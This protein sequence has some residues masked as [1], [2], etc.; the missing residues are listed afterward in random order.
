[1]V[2]TARAVV[3]G[4]GLSGLTCAYRLLRAGVDTAVVEA[5]D[6]V[7]GRAWRIRLGDGIGFDAGCEVADEAHGALLDL[8]AELAV[9]TTLADP[10]ADE[11]VPPLDGEDLELFL[12]FQ[13]EIEAVV[14][15]I[16]PLHPDEVEGA[17]DLDAQTLGGRLLEL[18]ASPRLL[19][20]AETWYAV[21]TS[22]VPIGAMSLLGYAA[23][24]AAGAAPNG[25]R[26]RF[27]GGPSE[28]AER[29]AAALEDRIG[30]GAEAVAVEDDGTGVLV[31]L[32]DGRTRRASRAVVATPL[33][34]QRSIRFDP[35]LPAHRVEGLAKA[36][37]G[38]VVK[39]GLLCPK[40]PHTAFPIVDPRGVVY[41]PDRDLPLLVFF[42]GS[43]AGRR[44]AGLA[45]AARRVSIAELVGAEPQAF[46]SVAWSLERFT[47]GSYLIFGPGDLT[48]WGRLLA[49]PH[50]RIHFA[51]SEAS[52]L[53]SYMN[54]A[55]LAGERAAREML[56]AL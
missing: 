3:V 21:A 15:R 11:L 50:G 25:L 40:L 34:V 23:K 54:G 16:D 2:R 43:E 48:S 13:E 27:A 30:F 42:A 29:L 56:E 19:E 28:L 9:T 8:A 10:W 51:G 22:T 4:A 6:R 32:A 14:E 55:V 26:I 36:R 5:R 49:T 39:A 1:L 20:V 53:P 45:E 18:G 12:L 24:L 41:R 46:R 47:Q 44:V 17:G 37:Y 38:D 52:P 35:A 31:R 7:G 33:T